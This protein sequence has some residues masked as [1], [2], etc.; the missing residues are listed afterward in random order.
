MTILELTRRGY[1]RRW[2]HGCALMKMLVSWSTKS[3]RRSMP[4]WSPKAARACR[5]WSSSNPPPPSD[6]RRVTHL[7]S[8]WLCSDLIVG[9]VD[10]RCAASEGLV[11]APEGLRHLANVGSDSRSCRQ[12][13]ARSR[14]SSATDTKVRGAMFS[15]RTLASTPTCS[16]SAV[17]GRRPTPGTGSIT[18]PP[19]TRWKPSRTS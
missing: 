9:R 7:H 11:P 14:A 15:T 2:A 1:V 18:V 4:T 3:E 6:P 8:Y 5:R 10:S 19:V 17:I 13:C 12:R 16:S